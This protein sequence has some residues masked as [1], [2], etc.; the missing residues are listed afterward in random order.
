MPQFLDRPEPR[1]VPPRE[2]P[3]WNRALALLNRD[4]RRPSPNRAR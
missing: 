3:W 2:H 4:L 1:Q